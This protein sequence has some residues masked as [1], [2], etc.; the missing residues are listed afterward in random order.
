MNERPAADGA[1]EVTVT[2]QVASRVPPATPKNTDDDIG[3]Q[4]RRRREASWRVPPLAGG[5]RD[6]LDRMAVRR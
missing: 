6:P 1:L 2:G 3:M 4:L 5:L